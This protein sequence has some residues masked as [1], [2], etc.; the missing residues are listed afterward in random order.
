MGIM[1]GGGPSGLI[2]RLSWKRQVLSFPF[3]LFIFSKM[4]RQFIFSK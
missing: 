4:I 3:Y 2:G 1:G